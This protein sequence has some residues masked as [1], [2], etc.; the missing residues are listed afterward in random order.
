M[1]QE[2]NSLKH[3]ESQ[4]LSAFHFEISEL[5]LLILYMFGIY[6]FTTPNVK[7]GRSKANLD[8]SLLRHRYETRKCEALKYMKI[9]LV[10][11]SPAILWQTG[12]F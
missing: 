11:A 4:V 3:L 6:K 12:H 1:D 7:L 8:H 9:N 10:T 2:G 5:L